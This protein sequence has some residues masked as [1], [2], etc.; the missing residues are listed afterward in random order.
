[1]SFICRLKDVHYQFFDELSYASVTYD[2]RCQFPGCSDKA[3]TNLS[4]E[5][6][7][8]VA[9]AAVLSVP[10]EANFNIYS[11]SFT[12]DETQTGIYYDD[13][14]TY[15]YQGNGTFRED[16]HHDGYE[17][18]YKTGE[19]GEV[20]YVR[21]GGCYCAA[22]ETIAENTLRAEYQKAISKNFVYLWGRRLFPYNIIAMAVV[23]LVAGFFLQKKS[24][25]KQ[26][27]PLYSTD[28]SGSEIGNLVG[29]QKQSKQYEKTFIITGAIIGVVV[30][31]AGL[32]ASMLFSNK[33]VTI[34]LLTFGGAYLL[35]TVFHLNKY[36]ERNKLLKH[37]KQQQEK[38]E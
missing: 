14:K 8:D 32:L 31:L 37:L 29:E 17:Y 7:D 35:V 13:Y 9:A 25:Q 36:F 19:K 33:V 28:L 11:S 22:H 4:A 10:N 1:M 30:I 34:V 26:F 18:S 2:R 27:A 3:T 6:Y 24:I 38:T 20:S 21:V 5:I 12:Y 15:S 16:S 23:V